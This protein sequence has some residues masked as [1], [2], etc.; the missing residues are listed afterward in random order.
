M[1]ARRKLGLCALW[2][3]GTGEHDTCSHL[4]VVAR[5]RVAHALPVLRLL[6]PALQV[7][8]A[9][10]VGLRLHQVEIRLWLVTS[11]GLGRCRCLRRCRC[12]CLAA[13]LGAAA[14]AAARRLGRRR[15]LGLAVAAR[16]RW[17]CR[18]ALRREGEGGAIERRVQWVPLPR[19]RREAALSSGAARSIAAPACGG[20]TQWTAPRTPLTLRPMMAPGGTSRRGGLAREYERRHSALARLMQADCSV[21]GQ[22]P[23]T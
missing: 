8:D 14:A 9:E 13:A 6:G 5:D 12:C 7:V 20:A 17:R 15:L 21:P 1:W 16:R 22:S 4:H 3:P 2:H 18:A 10:R 11:A 23:L 19:V